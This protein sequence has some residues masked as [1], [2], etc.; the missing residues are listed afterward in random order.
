VLNSLEKAVMLLLHDKCANKESVLISPNQIII[1]LLPKYQLTVKELDKIINN[2]ILDGYIDV[3]NS[4]NKGNTIYCVS[5]KMKG[6]A[7]K[8]DMLNQKKNNR[9]LLGRTIILA[10]ISVTITLILRA[11]FS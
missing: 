4:D 10:I 8:R 7:F 2:L 5:L 9:Y 3:I 6:I 1:S 11:I